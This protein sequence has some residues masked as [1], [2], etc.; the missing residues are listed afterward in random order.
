MKSTYSKSALIELLQKKL[1]YKMGVGDI[2]SASNELY[3]QATVQIINDMMYEKRKKFWAHNLSAGKKQVYYLSMEFLLGRSLRNSLFN[4][5]LAEAMEAALADMGV[6]LE[7]LYELEPDAGLG[8]GGLGRLASCYLDAAANE[9][10]L[11]TGYCILYEYGIFKQSIIDGWQY[12][13]PD[14]WLPGGEVWLTPKSGYEVPIR[15][16]GELKEYW[17]NDKH[18]VQHNGYSTVLAVPYDIHV[19]GFGS[20][21]VSLLRVWQAKSVGGMDMESFGRGDFAGAFQ[22]N[23]YNE[24]ISKV[25]YP[26]DNH[27]EGKNLRLRQ[28][29]FLCAASVADIFRRHMSVYGTF[30]NFAEKNAIHINDTHPT[31][32]IPE[33][34]RFLLDDCGYGWEKAWGIVHGTFAYTNHTVMKEAMEVWD[35]DLFRP[36]LPRI[37]SIISEIDRRHREALYN[38]GVPHHDVEQMAIIHGNRVRMANLAVVGSH[39]VNGVS[40]L[41][42]QILRDDVFNLFYRIEPHKFTNVTNGISSRR[43]LMQANPPLA[44]LIAEAIGGGFVRDMTNLTKLRRFEND[45]AFLEK[46]AATKRLGKEAFCADYQKRTGIVLDPASIFDVQV[47]RLHEY[48]RQQLNALDILATYQYLRENPNADFVPRTYLFGAK[49]APGYFMAKQIIKF[50]CALSEKIEKD[51]VIREKMRVVFVEDY[52]VT[53]MEMILPASEISEQISLAGTEASGTGNMKLM[54]NGAITLGTLDGANVEIH[55]VVGDD[56]IIIFG[57]TSS[58]VERL[59]AQGYNP[60]EIYSRNAVVRHAVDALLKDFGDDTFPNLNDMLKK[61]DYYMTL[62]D[63][64]SYREAR[65]RSAQ[66]YRDQRLWQK[67]ALRNIAESGV[68]C[69]DRSMNE[70]AENIWGLKR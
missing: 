28:Q 4:L 9:Q 43:W 30:D 31:L 69:A 68:F 32:A 52:N 25:L 34:M 45:A 42:S 3:Y 55:E 12:E 7:R 47:K 50:I 6:R 60:G 29:Y 48:K 8:N 54:L 38:A 53:R 44:K 65:E 20:D 13:L 40:R 14:D 46:L 26:N 51:P 61:S 5:G 57:M 2:K 19:P 49:A 58:E 21:S 39:C 62:A 37:Y 15:F 17:E 64:D 22:Q 70:Y 11:C 27:A 63:F 33:L 56:N 41:H 18:L 67:M 1:S 24:A 23:Y 35:V 10:Y 66:L 59:R 16:G 36:L